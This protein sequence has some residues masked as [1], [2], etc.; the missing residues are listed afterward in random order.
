MQEKGGLTVEKKEM[1]QE[2]TTQLNIP[3]SERIARVWE[4]L[5]DEEEAK[6]LLAMPGSVGELAEKVGKGEEETE[7]RL[8]ILF[9]KGVA[10]D[11]T[12]EGVTRYYLPR[13]VL[14]FHDA[15]ILWADAT[16]PFLDLW[17]E[18]MDTEYL[19]LFKMAKEMGLPEFFRVIPVNQSVNP[20]NKLLP[21]EDAIKI[22]E[23]ADRLAVVKCTC[24]LAAH[25]CDAPLENCMQLNRGADYAIRRGTGREIT[26][27]EAKKILREAAEAGLVH[28]IENKEG[29]GNVICNCCKCCCMSM[30]LLREFGIK[31]VISS[32]RYLAKVDPE[33]CTLCE[34]CLE[35][36]P[37]EAISLTKGEQ[38]ERIQ[39]DNEKC[40]GCGVCAVTCE[41][42]AL[43]LEQERPESF[44]PA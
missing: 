17:Q 30:P 18:F 37:M 22:V 3:P 42:E 15:S 12:K 23:E 6:L 4:M 28:E 10:F 24:R 2:L 25:R 27:E 5:C 13:N 20:E 14:Q 26:K 29:M 41:G 19:D 31:G 9:R 39:I 8:D 1:Y 43:L 36:C 11:R 38:E 35:R 34:T 21:H 32:S 16:Q 7:K 33:S 40:L 44:I